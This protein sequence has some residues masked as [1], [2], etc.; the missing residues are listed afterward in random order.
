MKKRMLSTSLAVLMVVSVLGLAG[1]TGVAAQ[2]S[3]RTMTVNSENEY[4]TMSPE[5]SLALDAS[6][7]PHISYLNQDGFKY[8]TYDGST[9]HSEPVPD[10]VI[11]HEQGYDSKLALDSNDHPHIM[12]MALGNGEYVYYTFFDGSTWHTEPVDPDTHVCEYADF[13]LDSSGHPHFSIYDQTQPDIMGAVRN[14]LKYATYD[15]SAWHV[16]TVDSTGDVGAGNSLAIDASGHP[17]I[18][19]LDLTSHI[20]KYAT[21]DGSTWN[22]DTIDSGNLYGLS[23]VLDPTNSLPRVSYGDAT[24]HILKY[25]TYDGSTWN[26]DTAD[27]GGDVGGSYT[28]L[29]LDGSG[30]PH[31]GYI[32]SVNW[33]LRYAS[34]DGSAWSTEI[35]DSENHMNAPSLAIDASGH[36]HISYFD[37]THMKTKY[38]TYDLRLPTS[39]AATISTSHAKPGQQFDISG[40]LTTSGAGQEGQLLTLS[41]ATSV[42]GPWSPA[43]L[44]T[45]LTTETGGAYKATTSESTGGT[46]YYKVSFAGSAV[47]RPSSVVTGAIQVSSPPTASATT[48]ST[49]VTVFDK[50][51]L[52]GSGSSASNGGTLSYK[53]S[54]TLPQGSSATLSDPAAQ[55]PTF[56]PDVVGSYK[57][58]LVVNDGT[59]D[60][61]PSELT[62]TANAPTST[63]TM[64]D[65]SDTQ[66]TIKDLIASNPTAFTN[67]NSANALTSKLDSV[68]ADIAAG[69]Y[70]SALNKLQ[71]DILPK[72]DGCTAS[73]Y[74]TNTQATPDKTDWIKD[75]ATQ[76][77]VYDQV[78][79]LIKEVQMLQG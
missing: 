48:P 26:I 7:H 12:H 58:Q 13:A 75:C 70:A 6:G 5:G 36:P 9:W 67:V 10:Y 25:A 56:V 23:L 68:K 63:T 54:L 27:N 62:I 72:T 65:V 50:V 22:I 64:S 51:S 37:M 4:N 46:Y 35:V 66:T 15:G 78:M 40:A 43:T 52:D 60:S 31:I 8:A 61:A 77:I 55:K 21:Y 33:D 44:A 2:Q 29:A 73:G 32:G 20:L 34:Y 28:S 74:P 19:Y 3:W 76:K 14:D 57:V 16:Q 39:L 11:V 47:Y 42:N 24:S 79:T 41:K 49:T 69:S 71:H 1:T 30:H 59:A 38:A 17:H 18:S 53:W 45:P